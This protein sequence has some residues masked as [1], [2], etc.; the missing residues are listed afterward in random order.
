MATIETQTT[1][2]RSGKGRR[3]KTL[4]VDLTAMV[5]VGF[6]LIMFFIFTSQ[7]EAM[8]AMDLFVPKDTLKDPPK[9]P[10]SGTLTLLLGKDNLIHFY[11]GIF[12]PRLSGQLKTVQAS[13]IRDYII[14]KKSNTDPEKLMIIIKPTNDATY[15]NTVDILDEM[16][17]NAIKRYVLTDIS[18]AEDA[19]RANL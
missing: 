10:E 5:D 7:L 1:A 4:L 9:S 19:A 12:D 16:T 14:Q 3:K 18:A 6:L 2:E 13:G 17:I 8:K 15:K 11:E